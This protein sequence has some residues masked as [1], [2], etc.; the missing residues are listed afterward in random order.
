MLLIIITTQ[1]QLHNRTFK[2]RSIYFSLSG[3]KRHSKLQHLFL[4]LIFAV[5]LKVNSM[6]NKTTNKLISVML[7]T[8][9]LISGKQ[10]FSQLVYEAE[11]YSAMSGIKTEGCSDFGGGEN[12][13]W[14]DNGDWVE[15]EVTI[16]VEGDYLFNFRVAG[17]RNGSIS[18][19]NN[20]TE[21]GTINISA[22]GGWQ[23]W[24][25]TENSSSINLKKGEH[26]IQLLATTGGFNINWWSILLTNPVDTDKPTAPEV[27]H[28]QSGVHAIELA[29]NKSKDTSSVVT[30][31]KV[32]RDSALFAFTTDTSLLLENLAANQK[33]NFALL[34]IDLAGNQS[35]QVSATV[36]TDTLPWDLAWADEF[37]YEG[38]PDAEKW[39]FETGGHG[40]GNGEYQYYT[41]GNNAEVKDGTL[42]IEARKESFGGNDFTSSRINSTKQNDFL[43]GRIEVK[44]KLPSTKGSWPAIWTLPTD[45][46]YGGWP[47]CGEIDIMEHSILT[48]YGHVFGTVHTGAYN[49]QDETQVSGGWQF[50][51]VTNTYHTY[52]I[53]WFPDRIE[54]YYDD[55][56]VFT[57]NNEYKTYAEWPY[58][59]PHHLILNIAVGGGLGGDVDYNGVWPQHMIIDYVRVYDFKLNENDTI[60]PEAPNT[61]DVTTKWTTA[62]L[63]WS[64]ARDNYGVEE[65]IVYVDG[66]AF[67]TVQGTSALIGGLTPE[68][69]Y[70][71]GVKAVDYA[72]NVSEMTTKSATTTEMQSIEI[73][74]IIEAEDYTLMEG[75]D[76]ENCTDDGG[77]KNVG[78]T[79]AGDW[80]TY[81]IDVKEN[82]D[83]KAAFRVAGEGA[84]CTLQ[85]LD[86]DDTELTTLNFNVSGGWQNWKTIVSEPFSL[87][88]G[89][90][91]IKLKIIKGGFNLNWIKIGNDD[92]LEIENNLSAL[93]NVYPNPVKGEYLNI[94]IP[95]TNEEV[96]LIF[97][98][99]DGKVLLKQTNT[100]TKNS[101]LLNMN[102]F[103]PGAFLLTLNTSKGR[104]TKQIIIE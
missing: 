96:E 86:Q 102:E 19:L 104:I 94:D 39:F 11:N 25:T 6:N 35:A 58:D 13:G 10:V 67:D 55:I 69:E 103:K 53:E 32:L 7:L 16:P 64:S 40:W 30:G 3:F 98:S 57:F 20:G 26:T 34:A 70:V 101:L 92:L 15:Y 52:A 66:T 83:Y 65:Y 59:I 29:W 61:L 51:D 75:I 43:Y 77:G 22:T 24:A 80:L 5:K 44:A 38:K 33:F 82:I 68:T 18:I 99:I 2:K 14:I 100:V 36:S 54:W 27:V 37:N 93:I 46:I 48:G 85:L 56:N 23:N 45:W 74:G 63:E 4:K 28:I 9:M 47:D 95:A 71:F 73:P 31:Y 88:T 42:I 21:L 91:E 89:V 84:S 50:S 90:Q 49:H 97:S 8:I 81:T 1:K 60:N 41:D 76:T 62:Q 87:P 17:E 12:V 78:W 79:D 72:G